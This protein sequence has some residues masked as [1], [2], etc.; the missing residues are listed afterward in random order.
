MRGYAVNDMIGRR[1]GLLT[2]VSIE[3]DR[4]GKKGTYWICRCDCGIIKSVRNDALRH[5][6]SCGRHSKNRKH[7]KTYSAAWY[8]WQNMI[9]RCREPKNPAYKN[10]GG[11]GIKVCNQ[12]MKF[13]NFY[14]DMGDPPDGMTIERLDV[15]GD[16]EPNNCRWATYVEQNNNR[17]DNRRIEIDGKINTLSEWCREYG[18]PYGRVARRLSQ[19]WPERYAIE[20]RKGSPSPLT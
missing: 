6:K 13:E 19:G 8:S 4:N 5:R 16:Y 9:R 2:V 18:Q 12:W 10:Y 20:A 11:R 14:A 15:D 3:P 17:R 7:G 1:F